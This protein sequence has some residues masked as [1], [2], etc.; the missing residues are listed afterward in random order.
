MARK[1]IK[2]PVEG[3]PTASIEIEI[4]YVEKSTGAWGTNEYWYMCTVGHNA[5]H[6]RRERYESEDAVIK[7]VQRIAQEY[8]SAFRAI[9]LEAL[10]SES[11][12]EDALQEILTDECVFFEDRDQSSGPHDILPRPDIFAI[13]V[14]CY[15]NAL[16]VQNDYSLLTDY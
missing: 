4:V 11:S 2:V 10:V 7:V 9:F 8:V 5:I 16:A 14:G 12:L 15:R 1:F 6:A 3:V 13:A